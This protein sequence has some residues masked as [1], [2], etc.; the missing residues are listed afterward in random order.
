LALGH[1]NNTNALQTLAELVAL[2][3]K[4]QQQILT[5]FYP[6]SG[7]QWISRGQTK[8]VLDI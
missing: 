4:G 5:L 8:K 1:I 3:F 7:W 6:E 2:V